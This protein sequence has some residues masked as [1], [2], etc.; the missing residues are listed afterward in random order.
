MAVK[1][2]S[3]KTNVPVT[4]YFPFGDGKEVEGQYGT[5]YQYTVEQGGKGGEKRVLYA[6]PR[7]HELL[8]TTEGFGKGATV[9]VT[10]V[11]TDN[12][13]KDW[14][15]TVS[16]PGKAPGSPAQ[17]PLARQE[18]PAAAPDERLTTVKQAPAEQPASSVSL[19]LDQLAELF[20]GCLHR[21][22][23][24]LGRNF[25]PPIDPEGVRSLATTLFIQATRLGFFRLDE[26]AGLQALRKLVERIDSDKRY[27][28]IRE[29]YA[30]HPLP[31]QREAQ[32][33]L[34]T[35]LRNAVASL[36]EVAADEATAAQAQPSFDEQF[37]PEP[38]ELFGEEEARSTKAKAKPAE[39]KDPEDP[40]SDGKLTRL[41]ILVREAFGDDTEELALFLTE[42][43]GRDVERVEWVRDA[44]ALKVIAALKRYIDGRRAA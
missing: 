9:D 1:K 10:K 38:P 33:Q 4:L 2:V 17:Q 37:P 29:R 16:V 35:E 15:V 44:E 21:A 39:D 11:E 18:S 28:P 13:R 12:N 22:E 32:A 27:E 43:L 8:M 6:T 40:I 14:V 19:V 30:L 23:V 31:A 42:A 7:L 41:R 24:V 25:E 36:D 26:T 5:Q 3:F 20:E 34:Y